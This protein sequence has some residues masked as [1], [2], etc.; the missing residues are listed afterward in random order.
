MVKAYRTVNGRRTRMPCTLTL[1]KKNHS[2]V[3]MMNVA[4]VEIGVD[5]GETSPK[6]AASKVVAYLHAPLDDLAPATN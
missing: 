3:A 4:P 6:N 2:L 5:E 1:N